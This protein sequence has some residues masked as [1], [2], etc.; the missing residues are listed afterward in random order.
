MLNRFLSWFLAATL[1]LS[2][3][4]AHA[5]D[6]IWSYDATTPGNNTNVGGIST[7]EGQL[8]GL[9]NDA[10]RELISQ[11]KRATANQGSDIS[12]VGGA[13]AICAT[14]TSAYVKVT[15]TTTITSFGTAAAGCSR[16]VTFTGALQITH[17][18]T[19][20]ILP[21]GANYTTS[22]GDMIWAVSEGSGNWRVRIFPADGTPV[23]T[24]LPRGYISGLTLSNDSGDLTNDIGIAAG[25]A[26]DGANAANL[27]LASA[28]IKR[29]DAAWAVGTNQGCLDGTESVAGTPDTSTW[30]HIWLIRRPDT[31][32]VDDLCSE[33]ATAP[34]MPTNYTQKRRIGAVFNNSSGD[35]R[36]FKHR[37]DFF[38]WDVPIL[39]INV[40]NPGTSAVLRTMT[41]P[42][43]VKVR[44]NFAIGLTN[45]TTS[46]YHVLITDPD[47][48]DTAASSSLWTIGVSASS[49]Y[50][51][52]A[53]HSVFTNTS[54]QIRTRQ[55]ASGA[56]DATLIITHGW[57]DRRGQDD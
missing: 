36:A 14:G 44:A 47:Q 13:P 49:A 7:A 38:Y 42:S 37:G 12:S 5:V 11:I 6:D 56:S 10:I 15:G 29:L 22:A 41:V 17:N 3:V 26:R 31:G 1:A 20:M 53:T 54:S 39:D 24:P 33:S 51:S 25:V 55:S 46:S 2:P 52:T 48:T 9:L 21:Y 43:G 34:T 32:V 50:F 28:L 23:L 8:P 16:W 30:Y 19:S 27:V 35:I 57:E 4:T 45:A 18:A 40:T